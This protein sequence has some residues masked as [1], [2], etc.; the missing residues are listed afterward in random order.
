MR[1]FLAAF[2]NGKQAVVIPSL[3][4]ETMVQRIGMSGTLSYELRGPK[5]NGPA[6][7]DAFYQLGKAKYDMSTVPCGVSK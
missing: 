7:Y 1:T 2:S 6:V 4:F 5:E 3:G